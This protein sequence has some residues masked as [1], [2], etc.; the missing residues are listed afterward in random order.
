MPMP[1]RGV[2]R[3]LSLVPGALAAC[4][5]AGAAARPGGSA[6][7]P[8]PSPSAPPAPPATPSLERLREFAVGAAAEP[9]F[10]F[11]ATMIRTGER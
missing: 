2:L 11:R 8:G 3:A 4:S 6:S 7:A 5:A 10:T 9:A 1:R